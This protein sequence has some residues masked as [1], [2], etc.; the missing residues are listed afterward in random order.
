MNL[1]TSFLLGFLIYLPLYTFATTLLG[2]LPFGIL[3]ILVVTIY[4]ALV[5]GIILG[6]LKLSNTSR[7]HP[8]A[9]RVV[10]IFLLP[11]PLF[12]VAF[13]AAMFRQLG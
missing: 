7:L 9:A 3:W 6:D 11:A 8:I 4:K 12:G 5:K 13:V 2:M 10:G 1:V